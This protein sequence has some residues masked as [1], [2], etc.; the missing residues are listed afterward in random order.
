MPYL[1]LRYDKSLFNSAVNFNFKLTLAA[2]LAFLS[3]SFHI[4]F[5]VKKEV[6]SD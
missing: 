2:F 3:L 1:L 6:K 5:R 4:G